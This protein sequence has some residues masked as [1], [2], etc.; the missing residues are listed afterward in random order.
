MVHEVE[1]RP[2]TDGSTSF[3]GKSTTIAGIDR[4]PPS[5]FEPL[6]EDLPP[7]L[8][9]QDIWSDEIV[10]RAG[11]PIVDVPFVTVG[12]GLASL[13]VVEVL[14]VAGVPAGS[15]KILG[16]RPL[17]HLNYKELAENSQIIGLDPL[18]S[19]SDVT[20]DNIWGF[21]GYALREAWHRKDLQPLW[22]VLTEPL[23]TEY[24][25]PRAEDFYNS[26]I[27]E[28]RR[29]G[30]DQMLTLGQA[31]VV[32]RRSQGGYFA[33]HCPFNA[34]GPE[35]I[36]Y[37]ATYV[38]IGVGYPGFKYPPEIQEYRDLFGEHYRVVNAYDPHEHVYEDL[39]RVSGTVIVRGAGIAAARII[40][41]LAEDRVH[42]GTPTRIIHLIRS[43]VGGP[44]GPLHFRRRG[45]HGFTW[46]DF[47]YSKA[48]MGGQWKFKLER[49]DGQERVRFIK[50]IG[51]TTTPYRKIWLQP[52]EA[53][54]RE[55]W[56]SSRQGEV[57]EIVPA[58]GDKIAVRVDTRDGTQYEI[59]ADYMIDC[60]GFNFDMKE[61]RVVADLYEHT[62]AGRNPMGRLDVEKSFEVRGARIGSGRM[63][64]SGAMTLGGY[65]APVDSFLGVQYAG[66]KIAD[67]LASV[68]FAKK[69]GVWRSFTQWLRW[70]RNVSP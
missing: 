43:Y 6:G 29:L 42:S 24:Y 17:P 49:L 25:N 36:A 38:H 30:W 52:M 20:M 54:R 1:R 63:Y 55:G 66:L 47:V 12:G 10:E 34:D 7:D 35:R 46:Q 28:T 59:V 15:I 69:I 27:K 23:L 39:R 56:Y 50:A 41:R 58:P 70:A 62:G 40:Q 14:R 48:A 18:R 2:I 19:P 37:R 16:A 53:G 65:Y 31:V 60:T 57:T 45:S 61:H 68:G 26:V 33:L 44:T 4:A 9:Q 3:E 21:P 51:G 67:D 32:R 22:K 5:G 64:A 11:I 8:L 13:G